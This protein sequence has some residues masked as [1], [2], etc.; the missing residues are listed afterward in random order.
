MYIIKGL[1]TEKDYKETYD[2]IF[3]GEHDEPLL[4]FAQDCLEGRQVTLRYWIT[5]KELTLQELEKLTVM[6]LLGMCDAEFFER[7]SE[8]TGYLWTDENFK[9]GGHDI[10]EEL[11]DAVGKYLYMEIS[12]VNG[13]S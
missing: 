10:L 1:I 3:V 7:Y 11:K 5:N 2:A 12:V 6:K 4:V 9:V 8:P 13:N